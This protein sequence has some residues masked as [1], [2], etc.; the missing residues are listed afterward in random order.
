VPRNEYRGLRRNIFSVLGSQWFSGL[1]QLI[2]S[3]MFI[4]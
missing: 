2:Y 4:A 1:F 3:G